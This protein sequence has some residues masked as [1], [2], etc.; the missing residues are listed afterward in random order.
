M[1][2][3][4]RL[5]EYARPQPGATARGRIDLAT[6]LRRRPGLDAPIAVAY[7]QHDEN[8][9][10]NQ[11]LLAATRLLQPW[12]IRDRRTRAALRR[13]AD[14]LQQVD[15][16]SFTPTTGPTVRWSRLNRH[17]RPAVEFARL[18]SQHNSVDLHHGPH[19][20]LAVTLDMN[21]IFEQF[22][23]GALREALGVSE[24][25]FPAGPPAGARTWT[26]SSWSGSNPT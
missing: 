5:V 24:V 14:S 13:I 16:V 22:V 25:E 2:K 6:Q 19:A 11:L 23:R 7:Q 9:V 3:A 4:Y 8:I 26:T 1:E 17:Y 20:T 21:R 15:R 18:L 10:E 12:P